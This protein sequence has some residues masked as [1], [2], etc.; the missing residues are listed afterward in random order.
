MVGLNPDYRSM[1]NKCLSDVDTILANA[2][3]QNNEVDKCNEL[4]KSS[5]T[6]LE[7]VREQHRGLTFKLNT[8]KRD[9]DDVQGTHG[10]IGFGAVLT[11]FAIGFFGARNT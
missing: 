7:K 6:Q 2:K 4:L 1:L 11:G 9:L 10:L 8:C 5:L 3:K